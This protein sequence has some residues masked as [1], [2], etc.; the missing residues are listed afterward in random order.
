M[1]FFLLNSSQHSYIPSLQIAM[2]FQR[3]DKYLILSSVLTFFH[4]SFCAYDYL[5]VIFY[6][7]L[8]HL[9]VPCGRDGDGAATFDELCE[10][11]DTSH[12]P[13]VREFPF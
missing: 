12:H 9:A 3:L 8:G 2:A 7:Y 10:V 1:C 4:E 11:Y 5:Y 6:Y 13:Q